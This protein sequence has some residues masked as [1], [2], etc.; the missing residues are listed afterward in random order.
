MFTIISTSI[1]GT[2]E[3]FSCETYEEVLE[4]LSRLKDYPHNHFLISVLQEG[5]EV[6]VQKEIGDIKITQ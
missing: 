5:N 6:F 3:Q 2:Q 1:D 4:L